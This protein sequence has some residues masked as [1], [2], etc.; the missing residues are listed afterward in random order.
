MNRRDFLKKLLSGA[1]VAGG[2]NAFAIFFNLGSPYTYRPLYQ[3]SSKIIEMKGG[4]EEFYLRPPGARG[5]EDFLSKC[6]KCYLCV[7]ACP[8]QAIKVAGRESR[9][10][11]DTPYIIAASAGCDLCLSREKMLC[12]DICP[13]DALAKLPTE[14]DYLFERM[15]MGEELNMGVAILDKRVCYAWTKVSLCWACYEICPYKGKAVTTG[16][17][18]APTLNTPTIHPENCVGCGLCLEICPVPQKAIAI[19]SQ[20]EKET[21]EKA[22]RENRPAP[23]LSGADE[24]GQHT[25]FEVGKVKSRARSDL[26][27]PLDEIHGETESGGGDDLDADDGWQPSNIDILNF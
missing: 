6:I 11:A 9:Y 15:K 26:D 10:A 20:E 8:I 18:K 16:D 12:N 21:I 2:V 1:V 23:D 5:E 19:V 13:T 3:Q 17:P 27:N 24:T 14:T 25:S 4:E 7:E 22:I